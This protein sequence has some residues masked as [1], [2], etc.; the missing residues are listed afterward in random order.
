MF[1]FS[2]PPPPALGALAGVFFALWQAFCVGAEELLALPRDI[3]QVRDLHA[4]EPFSLA[5]FG[6]LP[7]VDGWLRAVQAST[8]WL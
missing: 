2:T 4:P 3:T 5:H 6:S 8:Y 7:G 1:S